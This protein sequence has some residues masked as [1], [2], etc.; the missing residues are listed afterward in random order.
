MATLVLFRAAAVLLALGTLAH[1]F[2]GMLGTARNGVQAGPEADRVFAEMK[3][4][5]FEWRGGDCS[6]FGF[7]MGNGLGLGALLVLP[8]S[9]LWLLGAAEP[10]GAGPLLQLAVIV[11]AVVGILAA[12]GVRYFAPRVGAVFGLVAALSGAGTVLLALG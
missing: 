1:T 9:T 10:G 12:L 4:V 8:V 6:W 2:G 3:A 11:T 7:W 5:R